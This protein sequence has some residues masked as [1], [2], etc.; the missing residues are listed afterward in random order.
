MQSTRPRRVVV[1]A[2]S[3][4]AQL[5]ESAITITS[6]ASRSLCASRNASSVGEPTSSSPSINSV[7]PTGGAPS[8]ARSAARCA[9]MPGLVVGGA[10]AVEPAVRAR[11]ART[12]ASPRGRRRR[13][14]GRRGGRRAAR[15]AG[16]AGAGRRATTA[17]CPPSTSRMRTSSIPSSRNSSATASAH[18]RTSAARPGPRSRTG[19]GRGP[20][21]RRVRT[22]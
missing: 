6:A 21:G 7:T 5:P 3:P 14:A 20:R 2:G 19:C 17:G 1:S 9:A 13:S 18:R 4:I 16:P 8:C 12:A 15:S 11:S 10:A 22:A